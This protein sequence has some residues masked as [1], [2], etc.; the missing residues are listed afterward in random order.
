[1]PVVGER[2][3]DAPAASGALPGA[4]ITVVGINYAPESTGIA[5]Y[6]TDLARQLVQLG[7]NVTV[8]TGMPHYPAW[9]LDPA[10]RRRL[11]TTE[12]DAGVTVLRCRHYVPGSMDAVRRAWY[13]ASF[14]LSSLLRTLPVRADAVIAVSPALSGIGVAAAAS[15]RSSAPL[16]LLLQDVMGAAA[17]Q[18]GVLGGSRVARLTASAE[19]H[20]VRQADLVGVISTSFVGPV[21]AYGVAADRIR[22]LPNYSQ[23]HVDV[24]DQAAAR[25]RLGWPAGFC[26][27]HT[28]NM[29]LKQDLGNLIEA[30]RLLDGRATVRLVGDGSQR[31]DLELQAADVPSVQFV[32]PVSDE[33]YADVLAASDVLVVNER[34]TVRD[35]SLPSKLTSYLAAG[36]AV[37]AAA[38]SEG[39]TAFALR[40]SGASI[41]V[42]A[43]NPAAL[44]QALSSLADDPAA[45][46]SLGSAATRYA[47]Q[48]LSR[49]AALDR[50]ADF[51]STLVGMSGRTAGRR[52]LTGAP[53]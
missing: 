20:L 35:M 2:P 39:A 45:R 38:V 23:A 25:R 48:H 46:A 24:R 1:M 7:A 52:R 53:S 40:D 34:P 11:F 29:G 5:P 43:G 32:D 17:A 18:S 21:A 14:G 42:D 50:Y 22:L 6:T 27:T 47:A 31:G 37:V 13:E 51:V 10:Y 16:G 12:H 33:A 44:A 19:A 49:A 9:R 30:A 3:D 28:G 26:V 15:K 8:V 36:R 4:R 41:L